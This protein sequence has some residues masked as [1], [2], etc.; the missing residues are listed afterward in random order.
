MH[1]TGLEEVHFHDVGAVDAIVDVTGRVIAPAS[2]RR[3]ARARLGAAAGRRVRGRPARPHAGARPRRPP[4]CCAASRS[5]TPA[6][7]RELVTPTGAAILTTLAAS[8]AGRMPAMTVDRDRL[9][10]GHART[11]PAPPTCC[12]ASSARPRTPAR[13][14]T[15]AQLETTIDDMSPQLYEP[16]MERLFEAG[17]LDV[18]LTPVIMK[19]SRP[20]T[21]LTALCPDRP[22]RR[23]L[24]RPL[25]GIA[26]HRRALDGVSRTR[27][28]REM[29]TIVTDLRR[30]SRSR[31]RALAGRVVTVTPEFADVARIARR[32]PLPVREV[33]SQAHAAAAP[34]PDPRRHRPRVA[35][36]LREPTAMPFESP[37]VG[38]LTVRPSSL[39]LSPR[40]HLSAQ[41]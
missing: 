22:V 23:S 14:E 3:R 13:P 21:V 41:H 24:P 37:H 5:S 11:F 17:A 10:R 16:L 32:K 27:L 29:V 36:A 39:R 40:K 38:R 20:G 28:D 35:G 8:G 7:A 6:S 12:A 25:R 9:R 30:H 15:V 31:S 1:G 19:R 2:A 18:F 33:L 26:H 4:S 34:P